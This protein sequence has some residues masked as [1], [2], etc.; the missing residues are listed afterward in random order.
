MAPEVSQ[1]EDVCKVER[2][3]KVLKVMGQLVEIDRQLHER[4][5][6]GYID[7]LSRYLQM[8]IEGQLDPKPEPIIRT[9][10]DLDRF[11]FLALPSRSGSP[12]T[13]ADVLACGNQFGAN[14]TSEDLEQARKIC[15]EVP[16]HPKVQAFKKRLSGHAAVCTTNTRDYSGKGY[17][18]FLSQVDGKFLFGW[19]WLDVVCRSNIC[20]VRRAE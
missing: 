14:A 4:K 5:S 1:G 20:V 8:G 17:V 6:P 16:E 10:Y 19:D 13:L 7:A 15:N 2:A 11:E 9:V 18:L 12:I 3:A